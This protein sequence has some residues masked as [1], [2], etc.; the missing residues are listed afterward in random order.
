MCTLNTSCKCTSAS[1][2]S[3][4]HFKSC[5]DRH[6]SDRHFTWLATKLQ[7]GQAFGIRGSQFG[8]ATDEPSAEKWLNSCQS[9]L[10]GSTGEENGPPETSLQ[11]TTNKLL[12]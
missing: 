10:P 1:Y 4:S 6:L 7:D 2:E 9:Q 3:Q 11:L 12:S 5:Q 8:A